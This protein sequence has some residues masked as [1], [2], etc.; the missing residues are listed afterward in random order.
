MA[1]KETSPRRIHFKAGRSVMCSF[2]GFV[3]CGCALFL[4]EG[5]S[6]GLGGGLFVLFLVIVSD[7]LDVPIRN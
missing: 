5:V 3:V 4:R 7:Y 6:G 2:F 1:A